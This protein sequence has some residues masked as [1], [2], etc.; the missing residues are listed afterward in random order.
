MNASPT[1][2]NWTGLRDNGTTYANVFGNIGPFAF[3]TV[4]DASFGVDVDKY[5]VSSPISGKTM[6][7]PN[8]KAYHCDYGVR[9]KSAT[10]GTIELLDA[11]LGHASSS[12]EYN[13]QRCVQVTAGK[14]TLRN[15]D[16][17]GVAPSG[18]QTYRVLFVG[19][20]SLMYDLKAFDTRIGGQG[21][22]GVYL[23]DA[24]TSGSANFER[25]WITGSFSVNSVYL[26][27]TVNVPHS[28]TI[29]H[30][31]LGGTAG[32]VLN[33][34]SAS[35]PT[36]T[37]LVEDTTFADAA[38]TSYGIYASNVPASPSTVTCR[39]CTFYGRTYGIYIPHDAA[40]LCEYTIDEC[41]FTDNS[42]GI[43]D[44]RNVNA[45]LV[46]THCS[47]QGNTTYGAFDSNGG[48]GATNMLAENCFWNS[49]TGPA[50][51]SGLDDVNG[52]VDFTPYLA[53]PYIGWLIGGVPA[54]VSALGVNNATAAS[55]YAD[56]LHIIDDDAIAVKWTFASDFNG[57]TQSAY[58]IEFNTTMDFTSPLY[59]GSKTASA[60]T[61]IAISQA[62]SAGTIYFLRVR[63]WD[64][65][66]RAGP[67]YYHTF[68][69]NTVP[70]KVGNTN[71]TPID[72]VAVADSTPPLVFEKPTDSEEDS[73]HLRLEIDDDSGFGSVNVTILSSTAPSA[74][75]F[76]LDSGATWIG[77]P[78]G[79]IFGASTTPTARI[80]CT[81]P[82]ASALAN[83]TWH[84]R[85]RATDGF[86][87]S[88]WSDTTGITSQ[89][90][91][92]TRS[93]TISGRLTGGTVNNKVVGI[94]HNGAVLAGV[95]DN[96]DANGDF[97]LVTTA[98]LQAGDALVVFL[99][100]D[101][102]GGDGAT[103]IW[104]TG[105]NMTAASGLHKKI[106]LES[107]H[108]II[109]QRLGVAQPFPY[110]MDSGIDSDIP[111][112]W[113]GGSGRIQFLSA[114][115]GS[116]NGVFVRGPLGQSSESFDCYTNDVEFTVTDTGYVRTAGGSGTSGEAYSLHKLINNGTI[117]ITGGDRLLVDGAD[118]TSSGT[119]RVFD[120][121]LRL[122]KA[123]G[124]TLSIQQ[125][126]AEFRK[127]TLDVD[128][129][130]VSTLEINT[131][132]PSNGYA[133]LD[134]TGSTFNKVGL[135]V[136]T[137]GRIAE[138]D[139]N[140]FNGGLSTRHIFWK[141]TDSVSKRAMRGIQ[142]DLSLSGGQYNVEATSG[143]NRLDMIKS[144]GVAAGEAK[145]SDS[146]N[147]VFWS[148]VPPINVKAELGHQRVLVSWTQD[149]QTDQGTYGYHVYQSRLLDG[150]KWTSA[151]VYD[152]GNN[153]TTFTD[154][155]ANFT[156]YVSNGDEFHPKFSST[157]KLTVASVV[158]ATTLRVTGDQAATA[159]SG[160]SYTFFVKKNGSLLSGSTTSHVVESL[161]NG[162]TYYSYVTVDDSTEDAP[163]NRVRSA[164]VSTIPAQASITLSPASAQQGAV[165][166]VTI[167]GAKTH[168]ATT[169]VSVSGSNITVNDNIV[170]SATLV[171]SDWTI[172]PGAS[173]TGRTV[174]LTTNDVWGIAAYDEAP[175]ATF[176]VNT[177]S[178]LNRAT[179]SFTNPTADG[180]TSG[181]FTIGLSY[182]ANSGDSIDTS[183]LE[184]YAS[185]D[186]T[187]QSVN[188]T[189]GTNLAQIGSFWDTLNSTTA[190]CN[191][192]QTSGTELFSNG[193]YTV[194]ARVG[195]T[196]GKKSEWI[197]RRFYVNGASTSVAKT[198]TLLKQGDYNVSVVITGTFSVNVNA[199]TF[200]SNITTLSF[201]KDS[202]SQ[203]T[204][205]VAVDQL[206]NCGPRTFTV[207]MASGTDP[208][209]I[210]IVEYP[211]NVRP[212]TTNAEPNR[213]PGIGGLNVFLKNGAFFK[214]E[215]DIATRGRMMGIS[216]SRFYRSDIGYNGPLGNGWLG[217]YF[218]Q[219]YYD[220][221]SADIIWKTPDL[222]TE[223]FADVTGGFTPP[224]GIYMKAERDTT[225]NTVTLTDRHG[226]KCVFNSQGRLW[227]CIDRQGNFVECSYNFLGQL[228]KITDDRAK[229]WELVYYTHGRVQKVRDKVWSTG[230]PREVEYTY[231]S[232]G[233]LTEQKAPTTSRYDGTPKSRVTR[234]YRY[235]S[236]RLTEC[237]NPNEFA[238]GGAPASYMENLYEYESGSGTYRV[239][240]QRLGG[241]NQW[242]YLR[243]YSSTLI[244]ELDRRGLLT[245][246]TIDGTGRTT[247]VERYTKTWA[248]DTED[249]IDHTATPTEVAGKKRAADPDKYTTDFTYNSN[250]EVL[251][252]TYPRLNK[253]TY[254]YPNPSQ[255]AS[256]TASSISGSVLTD[257]GASW[258]TNAFA[259]MTLRM[260]TN[261]S[262]HRYYPIASNTSTTI[263]VDSVYSLQGD[264]WTNGSTYSVQN[265][266]PD[267]LAQ[268]NLLKVTRTDET[269]GD[270]ADIVTEYTY[271]PRFQFVKTVKNPRTKTTKY[272][273]D[274]EDS[275]TQ[276][277]VG[278]GN[279]V[280][281]EYNDVT[282]GQPSTQSIKTY[283]TYNEYGQPVS[284]TD[285]EGNVTLYKYYS[286][287]QAHDGF[288]YQRIAAYGTLDLTSE[289][290]Y[291]NVGNTTAQWPARAF[292]PGATKDNFK[293]TFVVNEFDQVTK[294]TGPLLRTS[295]SDRAD[296]FYFYDWNG[297]MTQTFR[298]YVTDAG[299]QPT[300][301]SDADDPTSFPAKA[302]TDMTATWHETLVKYDILNRPFERKVDAIAGSTI[303]QYTYR[304][305]Y[306]TSDNVLE[307]ISPLGNRSRT[308]YDERD[309]VFQRVSGAD[310]DV[311]A[312]YTTNYDANGNVFTSVDARGYTTTYVYDGF[313]R[314]TR[315][316]D[317]AG[318]YR[319]TDYDLNSNVTETRAK[320]VGNVLLA[321]T[322]FTYDEI[323]RTTQVKRLAKDLLGNNI[324]DGWQTS[325]TLFDKNSR[326]TESTD[327]N[328]V[329][330]YRYYDAASRTQFVRDARGNET[331]FDYNLDGATVKTTYR[332]V[333]DLNN[334]HEV[335]HTECT[336][337]YLNRCIKYRDQRYN[338]STNDT[339]R[340]TTF[341]GWS[342][343][344]SQK[345]ATDVTTDFRYD[346][347]SRTTRVSR[348]PG[349]SQSTWTITYSTYDA[350]SRVTEKGIYESP[351]T[352]SNPQ[353]TRYF[354]DERSRLITLQRADG[355]IYTR[356]YDANSNITQWSDP[357][358]NVV[359][360]TYDSR[361][362]IQYRNIT[363]G[364]KV[365]GATYE[366]YTFDGLGRLESCSNYENTRLMVAS[367][368]E[369]DTLSLPE[370]YDQTIGDSTG[371]IIGTYTTKGEYD[372]AGYRTA[373]I[374]H[375]GRRTEIT[376]DTLN[377]VRSIY[378]VTY[379]NH[380]ATFSYAGGRLIERVTGDG[381][382]MSVTYEAS[383]CGCGGFSALVERVEYSK[384]SDGQILAAV[385]RR[386]D[387]KGNM[388]TER[389]DQF[390]HLGY[391][392]RYDDAD[393]LTTS[394]YGVDLSGTELT[395]YSSPANTPGT[396]ALQRSF[397]LDQRGN[398]TGSNGVRDQ[399][400]SATTLE[401]T[402]YTVSSDKMN[403]YTDIDGKAMEY[404]AI[405]QCK[406]DR[407][408]EHYIAY[409]YRG[410]EVARDD[411]APSSPLGSPFMINT[412]DC[413]GR[414]CATEHF[415]DD[416]VSGTHPAGVDLNIY[417]VVEV[418][419]ACTG[420]P[421]PGPVAELK[422][423]A[424]G[425]ANVL[426][427]TFFDFGPNF[428]LLLSGD[429]RNPLGAVGGP[430]G[431]TGGPCRIAETVLLP[432]ASVNVFFLAIN[433][434]GSLIMR[435]NASGA[436]VDMEQYT[437]HGG[438]L[439]YPVAFDGQKS[440][441]SST[442]SN[443]PEA[444]I[445]K[446]HLNST[447]L[448]ADAL[449]GMTLCV[450]IP[451]DGSNRLRLGR[452]VDNDTDDIWVLD[453]D[454][455][456][457]GIYSGGVQNGF[458]VYKQQDSNEVL[459][460]VSWSGALFD[461]EKYTHVPV[462]SGEIGV[463]D[464][465]RWFEV[466]SG[467][468][469][470]VTN[471][472]AELQEL[473]F[474][475]DR[476]GL[477]GASGTS[478]LSRSPYDDLS[479]STSGQWTDE[480]YASSETTLTDSSAT[481]KSYMVGWQV[482]IDMEFPMALT[483]TA[484][485][486]ATQIKVA[487]NML[488]LTD[489]GK[490]Y[491]LF[492]PP[493]VDPADGTLA[494]VVTEDEDVQWDVLGTSRYLWA[495]YRYMPPM[496]GFNDGGI[497]K[498]AQ[499][500]NN[501]LGN[502]HCNN[503]VYSIGHGRWLS[504]DQ[505]ASPF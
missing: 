261:P 297:N 229:T 32:L 209:G 61:D 466:S 181:A 70:P 74:F 244:R 25:C 296:A 190:T 487:G 424:A 107:N 110:Q 310:S 263:T 90:F 48:S 322:Q 451:G 85:V 117:E 338:A 432:N 6:V 496:V 156:T 1:F 226:Y 35:T 397:N 294:V 457:A 388:T 168:C 435:T 155:N 458:V 463:A 173:A 245:E 66:D 360:N 119:L 241:Q 281:V 41:Q 220:S 427:T 315:V 178:N 79:G 51:G 91:A 184:L 238:Q 9:L 34:A 153:W 167:V 361:N 208:Q 101:A 67:W 290:D 413:L 480:S 114:I 140:T 132:T 68:R 152:G 471:V 96:T 56:Q 476:T 224:A 370:L 500:G 179:I 364:D 15:C 124:I 248:V 145:E 8:I 216:W 260:G 274:H 488:T 200:G 425:P 242:L 392:F 447:Y 243:Y 492:A 246:Y 396:F 106:D 334:A 175:T 387:K 282:V 462:T 381:T 223:T 125:G 372:G 213:N 491:I 443:T 400:D 401:D 40:N 346:L 341:D 319:E 486:S 313:D 158:S 256:G 159:A 442:T 20:G 49:P 69:T 58:E 373:K 318:H 206:A 327:D 434:L 328:G 18:A 367:H 207:D 265:A 472:D 169:T 33:E 470:R 469:L 83:G 417:D 490:F 495:G 30:C 390:G 183:T 330:H 431:D 247:K 383:G 191:V 53:R 186:V 275:A 95:T 270:L 386:Y 128:A 93:Y 136:E 467:V 391:V 54:G 459:N 16:L 423:G 323:D 78:A 394:Y 479:Y 283:M 354:Y 267:P 301:P 429:A 340:E 144:G 142:F 222:R 382:K 465:G 345:D 309:M 29:R 402:N 362:F 118:S 287:G 481:F 308:V 112:T 250:H 497:T 52:N 505:A 105:Q 230:S 375:T 498:G 485:P 255:Q 426:A 240:A 298:E 123:G 278:R 482:I 23:S 187:V 264:G 376:R 94:A 268:G 306:D 325:T 193:E 130:D 501:K 329:T 150:G 276:T 165:V 344:T 253:V 422:G 371:S 273:Y 104:F 272:F 436:K 84:W 317:P 127:A 3:V 446:I 291:D 333:N 182:S 221:G 379:N 151:P 421:G 331:S 418:C 348:K 337:D 249:P 343:V 211:T 188:R 254:L 312:T 358:G 121:T 215:T 475:G 464:I 92:L 157:T 180:N 320:N 408:V 111:W 350:D 440:L 2:T 97:D 115:N 149:D 24:S 42:H 21:Q 483:I 131:L 176:T 448:S 4:R 60:S 7:L 214:G 420:T 143:A 300:A 137:D 171:L 410:L 332:E 148:V 14:V 210:V 160:D 445:T 288:L 163:S 395:T 311:A 504:P 416:A 28:L 352:L 259:G 336:F 262:N 239:V 73:L 166:A 37:V 228:D 218:Q 378:D 284:A 438:V 473:L 363:R 502:Y 236:H 72:G 369:Y 449:I 141:C 314:T 75:E 324:G 147:K 414:L 412:H 103:V 196:T 62:I 441:I 292:E 403:L 405:E 77:M 129:G 170:L 280:R 437:E 88:A 339:E 81:V 22:H 192:G 11:D 13:S 252:V 342:R 185:R 477:F 478:V 39:R 366:C 57:S 365:M 89:S 194:T 219:C 257:S 411:D 161:T 43:Y 266:N 368:W 460:T 303:T 134:C 217:F 299:S 355:D 404:D 353:A 419:P 415:Y 279:L 450:S 19:A 474:E 12:A 484:V 126:A 199:V 138:F 65:N 227:R 46:A 499:A 271:E 113:L 304:T 177:S 108:V 5:A 494:D 316:T 154:A 120:S 456:A 174:T 50:V 409:D 326:V 374:A 347:L 235:I 80:R 293:S 164:Q 285:G 452:V 63:L 76:S 233:D 55:T 146:N 133:L 10:D 444:G 44:A 455:I 82:A 17:R 351:D 100:D 109:E 468:W 251:T 286:D 162:T 198:T 135:V 377:R 87:D 380:I 172:E 503:R 454:G 234:G 357:E 461:D 197:T 406:R 407:S 399:D 439:Q 86:E 47:F 398:R 359:N 428:P 384:V 64:A 393:R 195:N 45:R 116:G 122:K 202:S 335:S 489:P 204:A 258:T 433:Q 453:A 102:A 36:Y 295:G 31:Y 139:N 38:G 356:Q 225:H 59:N 289:F 232:N 389:E 98:S 430:S 493:Y 302:T 203:V 321:Q 27:T 269:L 231:D 26:F 349:A 305:T 99:N 277:D 385:D 201:T 307:S 237:I 205:K 189:A 71:R 212:T